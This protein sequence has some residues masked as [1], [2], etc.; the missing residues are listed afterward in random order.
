VV[1]LARRHRPARVEEGALWTHTTEPGLR[2]W[3]SGAI[4]MPNSAYETKE[5]CE[6]SSDIDHSA[7]KAGWRCLPDTVDPRGPKG[8]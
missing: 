3:W 5:Q 8:K 6:S 7:T 1:L 2:G 4:W